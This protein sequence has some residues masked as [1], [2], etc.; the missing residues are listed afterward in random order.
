MSR[1][2]Q[3]FYADTDWWRARR[4]LNHGPAQEALDGLDGV[5]VE[6]AAAEPCRASARISN[7][8]ATGDLVRRRLGL[9]R[10]NDVAGYPDRLE[11]RGRRALR[12]PTATSINSNP[13][14]GSTEVDRQQA[15]VAAMNSRRPPRRQT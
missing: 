13:E 14:L 4:T 2:S 10:P 15:S 8:S 6:V 11:R 12:D 5:E 9:V 1:A 3:R 7:C